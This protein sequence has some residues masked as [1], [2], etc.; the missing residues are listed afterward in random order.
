MPATRPSSW[1]ASDYALKFLGLLVVFGFFAGWLAVIG[2]G[3][4]LR[5]MHAIQDWPARRGVITQ[6]YARQL[7]GHKN[8]LYWDVE[9]AGVYAGSEQRFYVSRV[10]YGIE[11]SIVTRGR[12]ERMAARFPVGR[13]LEV[14]YEPGNPKHAV[15]VRDN[16]P[17]PTLALLTIGLLLGLLP[18]VLYGY[19]RWRCRAGGG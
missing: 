19:S 11:Q 14:Y 4:E 17:T 5:R 13:E 12:A 2:A 8:R 6:S 9:I 15:L 10:G 3:Y 18:L 16:S 7:R 1:Q